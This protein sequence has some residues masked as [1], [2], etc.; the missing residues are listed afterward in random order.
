MKYPKGEIGDPQNTDEKKFEPHKIPTKQIGTHKIPMRK[1]RGPTKNR[2]EKIDDP[3]TPHEGT[4]VR[5]H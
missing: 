5:C 3:R 1:N 4:M 2:R